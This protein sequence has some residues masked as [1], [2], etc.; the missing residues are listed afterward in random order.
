MI[1]NPKLKPMR[2]L[3]EVDVLGKRVYKNIKTGEIVEPDAAP[4]YEEQEQN[5]FMKWFRRTD[6]YALLEYVL[7]MEGIR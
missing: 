4:S 6:E 1:T 7:M 5:E 2:G 3:V